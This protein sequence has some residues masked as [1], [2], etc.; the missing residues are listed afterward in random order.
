M[1]FLPTDVG[2]S[3]FVLREDLAT[4]NTVSGQA[5]PPELRKRL[6][7]IGWTKD[8][9]SAD[10]KREWIM[11]P[12]SLISEQQLE[13]MEAG[14]PTA[15]VSRPSQ[16]GGLDRPPSPAT[17]F[18]SSPSKRRSVFV[19]PLV[20]ILP[21]LA[22]LA[23]D[24]DLTVANA[25]RVAIMNWMRHDPALIARPALDILSA[26]DVPPRCL[27]SPK[28]SFHPYLTSDIFMTISFAPL[29]MNLTCLSVFDAFWYLRF[30]RLKCT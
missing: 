21:D 15:I 9:S 27:S 6:A 30:T 8:E 5:L 1:S 26:R 11:T 24:I 13:R 10:Q 23:Y 14:L 17:E 16:S 12:F 28:Y 25:A 4:G 2:S 29:L 20:S 18:S 22:T 3:S 19:P 7:D